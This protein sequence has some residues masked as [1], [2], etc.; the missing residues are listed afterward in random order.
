VRQSLRAPSFSFRRCI[1]L[2][3]MKFA[4]DV[5]ALRPSGWRIRGKRLLYSATAEVRA[6]ISN[7]A[8]ALSQPCFRPTMKI[9][10]IDL[11]IS[12][13]LVRGYPP[14]SR[15][16]HSLGYALNRWQISGTAFWHSGVPFSVLSTPYSA[17]GNGIVQSSG[18]Q[19]VSVVPGVPL[20]AHHP[21]P[22]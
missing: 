20:Y 7:T 17:N 21:V 1:R 14:L 18:P 5:K 6:M 10:S 15:H 8:D 13:G 16:N 19:F 11:Q 9:G 4:S 3:L 12:R 22:A 2:M